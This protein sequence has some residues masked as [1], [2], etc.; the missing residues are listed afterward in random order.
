M[1]FVRLYQLKLCVH[2]N[3]SLRNNLTTALPL[4]SLPFLLQVYIGRRTVSE[5]FIF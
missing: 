3:F 4:T 1:P 5:R 2:R